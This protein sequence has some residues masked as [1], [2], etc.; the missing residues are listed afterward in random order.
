MFGVVELKYILASDYYPY[1]HPKGAISRDQNYAE[2]RSLGK[3]KCC[4]QQPGPIYRP[5]RGSYLFLKATFDLGCRKF[6][7]LQ[8]RE[9]FLRKLFRVV[10]I[11]IGQATF[12]V[13]V[14]CGARDQFPVFLDTSSEH[15]SSTSFR[16]HRR[17]VQTPTLIRSLIAPKPLFTG[18]PRAATLWPV[19][20]LCFRLDP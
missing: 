12:A 17:N 9:Q 5:R 4:L 1:L 7:S 3:Q 14:E 2:G 10:C 20:V 11:Y 16:A 6:L 19:K 8:L 18:R 13:S 15:R